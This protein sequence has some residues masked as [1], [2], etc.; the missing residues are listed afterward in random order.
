MCC[1]LTSGL[2]S[3]RSKRYLGQDPEEVRRTGT[4]YVLENPPY[5]LEDSAS[6]DS[7]VAGEVEKVPQPWATKGT[8][9]EAV[10]RVVRVI[11]SWVTSLIV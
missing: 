3:F 8:L 1:E 9:E 5:L 10:R 7:T 4:L 11:H 2:K 6:E